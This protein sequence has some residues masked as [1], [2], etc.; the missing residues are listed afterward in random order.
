MALRK[1][2]VAVVQAQGRDSQ[3]DAA[4]GIRSARDS[5]SAVAGT[6]L[7]GNDPL[8]IRYCTAAEVHSDTEA[9]RFGREGARFGKEVRMGDR[10]D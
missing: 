6:D 5:E 2:G 3:P 4:G 9:H 10:L 7:V 1:K 8:G